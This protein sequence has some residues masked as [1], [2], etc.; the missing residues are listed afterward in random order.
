MADW[1]RP[2]RGLTFWTAGWIE[3]IDEMRS[4]IRLI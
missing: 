3:T 4:R 2:A 1:A